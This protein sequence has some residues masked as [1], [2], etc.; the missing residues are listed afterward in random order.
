MQK[1]LFT[2]SNPMHKSRLSSSISAEHGDTRMTQAKHMNLKLKISWLTIFL[3]A[4]FLPLQKGLPA[5]SPFEIDVRD[6]EKSDAK[7]QPAP[8]QVLKQ[9]RKKSGRSDDK[10]LKYSVR[11][12]DTVY[13]ILTKRFGLSD[14][15]AESLIPGILRTNNISVS[16]VLSIGRTLL[17]P[18]ALERSATSAR[19]H[20]A[21]SEQPKAAAHRK[22]ATAKVN[23]SLPDD[24]RG[25]WAKL[26]PGAESIGKE[27]PA[28]V[29]NAGADSYPVLPTADGGKIVIVPAGTPRKIV[30][31]IALKADGARIIVEDTNHG[32]FMAALLKAAGFDRVDEDAV[33]SIGDDPKLTVSVDFKIVRKAKD[34]ETP[35][36]ILLTGIDR[37]A[38][39]FPEDLE[40]FLSQKGFRVVQSCKPQTGTPPVVRTDLHSI[41]SPEQQE[42]VDS[43]L[44]V[45]SVKYDKS[46]TIGTSSV[47]N[48]GTPF[49]IKADRY[50]EENGKRFIVNFP[51]ND[52]YRYTVLHLLEREDYKLV[53]IGKT[54][55][56]F[57]IS[58]KILDALNLK[59]DFARRTLTCEDGRFTIELSSF[60]VARDGESEKR[61]LITPVPVDGPVSRLITG[62]RWDLQQNEHKGD[63]R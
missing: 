3:L 25:L 18:A 52:P 58:R 16:T 62:M 15:R 24:I 9:S 26:F 20:R 11:R 36:T 6:L 10:Y 17:L 44:N 31:R 4:F 53:Q 42:I 55:G 27:I 47:L 5:D 35:E 28:A 33:I 38:A 50:F 49:N 45:L 14:K 57:T 60:L 29:K 56:F 61:L 34:G 1:S 2:V 46:R 59:Q 43:M 63:I 40:D 22:T 32:R 39:C 8:K 37:K 21:G 19:A 30:D 12:G 51:N 7:A 13:V 54:D 48:G 23:A 41:T